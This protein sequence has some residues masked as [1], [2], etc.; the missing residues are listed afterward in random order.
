MGNF[1][2]AKSVPTIPLLTSLKKSQPIS[3]GL[4]YIV[5]ALEGEGGGRGGRGGGRVST[6]FHKI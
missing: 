4:F 6:P 5:V 3:T 2:Q 1:G